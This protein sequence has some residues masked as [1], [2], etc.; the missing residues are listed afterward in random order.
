MGVFQK[1]GNALARFMYG[2]NGVDQLSL[3]IVVGSLVLDLI[4][5]LVAPHLL[6]LGNVL[7]TVSIVAWIYALFRIFSKNLTKRR[8]ENQRWLNWM[9]RMKSSSAG[10]QGPP[11][12]QGPQVLHLQELQDHLPGA[13]GQGEDHHHL[14]QV[15]RP[16]PRQDVRAPWERFGL[17]RRRMPPPCWAS[18]G[19]T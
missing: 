4:S 16:D 8:S 3:V 12:G 18:M 9:W 2:R 13:G 7:Y 11:R 15:R 5:M 1:I 17:P 14:P 19:S 6:W 10:G